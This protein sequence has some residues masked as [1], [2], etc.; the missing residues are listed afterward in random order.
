MSFEA[1]QQSFENDKEKFLDEIESSIHSYVLST[2][3]QCIAVV[4][5]DRQNQVVRRHEFPRFKDT[6]DDLPNF[7]KAVIK[8]MRRKTHN[9]NEL[10]SALTDPVLK[11]IEEK[12]VT[13][14]QHHSSEVAEEFLERLKKDNVLLNSFV[15][16]LTDKVV[17]KIAAKTRTQIVHQL[18]HQIRD[19]AS[20]SVGHA[21]GHQVAHFASTA[22]G[23]QIV[24]IA[25]HT[26]LKVVA[27]HIGTI[28]T[29][30]L[31]SAAFKKMV[32]LLL[33]K[34]L[35]NVIAAMVL[36]FLATQVG[37][38][39]GSS[40]I[41]WVILPIVCAIMVQEIRHFPDKLG[42]E[43]GCG[44]RKHLSE[45]FRE[46]NTN[47]LEST[48]DQVFRG[49]K[50]LECIAKDKDVQEVMHHLAKKVCS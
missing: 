29:H 42:R 3:K 49:E 11:I 28:V 45:S 31:A 38:T 50:L 26:I 22:V 15:E 25:A 20:S 21:I 41:L 33:K 16:R 13:L 10:D 8:F 2:G 14:Y 40:F 30:L 44:V 24:T 5:K 18:V 37:A 7:A 27:A 34:Y 12:Y 4:E 19:A 32:A 9:G 23:S 35:V 43:L 48:F 6:V 46:T 1:L 36:K 47:L 39:I 17:S